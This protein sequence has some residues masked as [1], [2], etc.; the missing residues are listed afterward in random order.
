MFKVGNLVKPNYEHLSHLYPNGTIGIVVETREYA[1]GGASQSVRVKWVDL[2][3]PHW[4]VG[5]E[6]IKVA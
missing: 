6:L 3:A 1:T 5:K 2:L 4:C